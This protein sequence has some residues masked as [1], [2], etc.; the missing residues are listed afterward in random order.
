MTISQNLLE[1]AKFIVDMVIVTWWPLVAGFTISGAVQAFVS[2]DRLGE[3][4]GGTSWREIGIASFFGFISSSCSFAAVATAR[5]LYQK[6]ASAATALAAYQ[7]AATNL[8]IEIAIVIWI[9]L[10]PTFV[11]AD[12]VGGLV[13]IVLLASAFKYFVPAGWSEAAREHAQDLRE[14]VHEHGTDEDWVQNHTWREK[15]LTVNGWRKASS[16][17]LGEWRM[18]WKEIVVGFVIAGLIK[19]F[20]PDSAWGQLFSIFPEGTLA[21]VVF[22]V[23]I[24]VAIG[25]ATFVCS[26]A[27]VPLALVLWQGGIPFGGVMSFIFADLIVPHIVQMYRKF[28]GWRMAATM[29]VLIFAAAVLSGLIIHG[30]WAGLAAI[31]ERGAVGGT[32]PAGYTKVLDVVFGLVF[33]AQIYVT[34]FDGRGGSLTEAI[35]GN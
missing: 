28:Y 11:V 33:L 25:V 14:E 15:L 34:Y 27:N 6:G 5:S 29:F 21:W 20:V 35:P 13:L 32:K 1:S 3:L 12:F 8:V 17:A 24:G 10:N 22:G 2:Q 26:V 19:G 7:F 18:L 16:N 31:P 4:I 23:L 30:L 9:V